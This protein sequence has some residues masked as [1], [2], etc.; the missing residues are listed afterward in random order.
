MDQL[1]SMRIF[2]HIV[3]HDGFLQASQTLGIPKS[4]ILRRMTMLESQLGVRLFCRTTR[5]VRLTTE[6]AYYYGMCKRILS[7]IEEAD[8]RAGKDRA[9]PTELSSVATYP[10]MRSEKLGRR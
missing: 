3:D 9:Q 10:C 4:A 6:G 8:L 1:A 5:N 2:T 7:A